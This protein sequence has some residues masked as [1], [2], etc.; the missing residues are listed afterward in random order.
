MQAKPERVECSR[1][2]L[3]LLSLQEMTA[4]PILYPF[5]GMGKHV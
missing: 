1:K 3:R 4:A 5:W 2:A